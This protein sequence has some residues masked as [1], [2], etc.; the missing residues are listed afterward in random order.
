MDL[1]R[2]RHE[3]T[4]PSNLVEKIESRIEHTDVESVEEYVENILRDIL[5]EVE[6]DVREDPSVYESNVEER[7]RML[8]Y[9]QD[10]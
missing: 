8:G 5:Y 6:G 3:I 2:E 10:E 9:L 1:Q 4:L 7:L